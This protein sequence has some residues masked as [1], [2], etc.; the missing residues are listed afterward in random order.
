[1]LNLEYVGKYKKKLYT[2][3]LTNMEVEIMFE[4]MVGGWFRGAVETTYNNFIKVHKPKKEQDLEE[5][6][7][8]ALMQIE[9]KH[10]A[11]QLISDG[12]TPDRIKKYGF[13]FQ[14]KTCLIG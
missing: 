9:E 14:G 6:V 11:A 7:K 12:I 2:L 8:K 3:A 4:N 10:Y 5:T 13:A 1:M